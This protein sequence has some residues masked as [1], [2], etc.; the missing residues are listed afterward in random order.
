MR[1]GRLAAVLFAVA[2]LSGLGGALSARMD[3]TPFVAFFICQGIVAFI[4]ACACLVSASS[5][6]ATA[7][8]TNEEELKK[9]RAD[10]EAFCDRLIAME[11]RARTAEMRAELA[12]AQARKEMS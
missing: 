5:D 4:G 7:Y 8:A 3:E 11:D 10:N 2:W 12:Q 1:W 9:L 6:G